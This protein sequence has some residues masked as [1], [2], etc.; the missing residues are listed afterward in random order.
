MTYRNFARFFIFPSEPGHQWAQG[1]VL[2]VVSGLLFTTNNFFVKFLDIDAA[3]MLLV[4]CGLQAAV[5]GLVIATSSH[6]RLVPSSTTDR[7]LVVLQGLCSGGRVFLQFACL[8]YLALGDALTLIF[9]EPLWTL[10][11]SRL[12]L[13]ARIG[14]WKLAFSVVLLGGMLLCIQVDR[15]QGAGCSGCRVRWGHGAE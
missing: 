13:G 6:E 15:V 10:V 1:W 14:P 8:Q 11:A 3:E 12:L 7:V 5:L 2:A 9:T 4:R